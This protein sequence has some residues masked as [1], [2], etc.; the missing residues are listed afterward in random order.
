VGFIVPLCKLAT[1]VLAL[2]RTL[3]IGAATG[4]AIRG[5]VASRNG[6]ETHLAATMSTTL[7]C[8]YANLYDRNTLERENTITIED[9]V[10]GHTVSDDINVCGV[11]TNFWDDFYALI[12]LFA[13]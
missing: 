12:W 11:I 7:A 5:A 3:S 9:C 13:H 10:F 2:P 4:T 1:L 8:S 6:T